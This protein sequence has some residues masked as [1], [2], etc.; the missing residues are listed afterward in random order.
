[1]TV[2]LPHNGR[3]IHLVFERATPF[4]SF[5]LH[6]VNTPEGNLY[7]QP[8]NANCVPLNE[9]FYLRHKAQITTIVAELAFGLLPS[10]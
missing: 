10:N 9:D 1:M 6:H 3:C 7:I 4:E 2:T 5:Q 8:P